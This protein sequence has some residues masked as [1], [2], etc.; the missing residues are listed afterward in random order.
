MSNKS[1]TGPTSKVADMTIIFKSF[2]RTSASCKL[3]ARPRSAFID[4]SWN[5]SK[6]IQ[7][8]LDR[9]GSDWIILIRMPSVITTIRVCLLTLLSP[10]I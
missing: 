7:P 8:T 4:R 1:E 3:S 2:R 6:I 5:S 9:L 10:L